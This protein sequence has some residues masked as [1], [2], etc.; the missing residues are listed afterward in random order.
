MKGVCEGGRAGGE[1]AVTV[2]PPR[3]RS[4]PSAAR[5][6]LPAALDWVPWSVPLTAGKTAAQR[7]WAD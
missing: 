2:A 1:L 5:P 4:A 3:M 6:A 7:L